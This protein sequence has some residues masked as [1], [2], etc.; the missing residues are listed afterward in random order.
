MRQDNVKVRPVDG[1]TEKQIDL[2]V[3]YWSRSDGGRFVYGVQELAAEWEESTTNLLHLVRSAGTAYL[4]QSRCSQCEDRIYVDCRSSLT[5]HLLHPSRPCDV[6]RF[7]SDDADDDDAA[8]PDTEQTASVDGASDCTDN[9]ASAASAAQPTKLKAD[10]VISL[11]AFR[12]DPA[13]VMAAF[14][15]TCLAV[16]DDNKPVFYCIPSNDQL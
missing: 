12:R 7:G 1:A 10:Y 14:G 6:C 2:L 11:D 4:E 15:G 3:K 13:S 5:R 16:L 9:Y 8:T